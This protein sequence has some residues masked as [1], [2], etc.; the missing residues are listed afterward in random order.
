MELLCSVI[1]SE[2]WFRLR[3]AAPAM[4]GKRVRGITLALLVSLVWPRRAWSY[5]TPFSL[6]SYRSTVTPLY[7]A[8]LYSNG[9]SGDTFM[10]EGGA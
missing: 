9:V 4:T 5:A 2:D 6:M 8:R 1:S 7:V 10:S 3:M